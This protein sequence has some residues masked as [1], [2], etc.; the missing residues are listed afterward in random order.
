MLQNAVS[1]NMYPKGY[2]WENVN[3]TSCFGRNNLAITSTNILAEYVFLLKWWS[4][5]CN[6][7]TWDI[8]PEYCWNEEKFT[9][10]FYLIYKCIWLK[11]SQLGNLWLTFLSSVSE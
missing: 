3:I 9:L 4:H 8:F 1:Q 2:E 7:T 10:A 6:S 5:L 11:C